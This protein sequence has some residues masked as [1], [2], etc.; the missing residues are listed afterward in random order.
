MLTMFRLDTEP[1][2][3]D[4]RPQ[5]AGP[6]KH[7]AACT[8]LARTARVGHAAADN[9]GGTSVHARDLLRARLGAWA[10]PVPIAPHVGLLIARPARSAPGHPGPAGPRRGKPA[11]ARV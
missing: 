1:G 6:V 7:A 8:G 2:W 10:A 5:L 4:T 3:H 9:H 11:S